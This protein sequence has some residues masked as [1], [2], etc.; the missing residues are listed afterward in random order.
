MRGSPANSVPVVSE[1]TGPDSVER[2]RRLRELF[3]AVLDLPPTDRSSFLARETAGDEVLRR[4]VDALVRSAELTQV[5]FELNSLGSATDGPSLVGQRLGAYDVVRLIGLGGM[6]A[7]YEAV[8]ADDQYRQR[9][10]I[11]LVQRGLDSD[12]TAQRFR[13]E[14]QILASLA[15]RNIA[16]LLDGGVSA[17]GRPYLVMEYVEGEPITRWCDMRKLPLPARLA[18]FRQVC[19]AVQ[20]AHQNLVVH[21]DLKPGNILVTA[22]GTVKLLDFGIAKLMVDEE[23]EDGMPLTRGGA[24]ILTPEYASPEQL[25]GMPLSTVSDV[26]SLGVL[27][28]ELVSG[29]RPHIA[30][31]RAML[32]LEQEILTTTAPRSSTLATNEAAVARGERSGDRLR[33]RLRGELDNIIAMALR[34]EPERRYA[35]VEALADDLRRHLDGLPVKAQRDWAGYRLRKFVQRN[36]GVV[37]ASALLLCS[38]V[39]GVL[40]STAQA[41][42]ARASQLQSERVNGFLTS[43]LSSVRPAT[44]G[45]DVS[46]GEVLDAVA[47]KLDVELAGEP[48]VRNDLETVVGQSYLSLGRFDDAER[49]FHAAEAAASRSSGPRSAAVIRAMVNLGSVEIQR[50]EFDRADSIFRQ[51]EALRVAGKVKDETL[52]ALI[53]D[54]FGS[55][56]HEVGRL[57]DA[58][59]YHR[60]AMDL[61]IA[62]LGPQNDD[63]AYSMGSV[64]VALGELGRWSEAEALN[65]RSL[66]ILLVNHP[67]PNP[68]VSDAYNALA[69]TL[70]FEGKTAAAESA[71]VETLNIRRVLYGEQHPTYAWTL[72]NYSMF[73]FDQKRFKEAAEY[74]RQILALR[75]T[76]LPESHPSIAAALQ[77]LGRCLDQLGEFAGGEAALK[78]SLAIRRKYNPATSWLI[79]SSKSVLGEHYT[80]SKDFPRAES[81]LLPSHAVFVKT[82]GPAHARTIVSA[83]RLVAL[84]DAWGRPIKAAPYRAVVDSAKGS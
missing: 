1:A 7:V 65:R 42:R 62:I 24:R 16:T 20:H 57:D 53:L 2:L 81:L 17:D 25:Q 75:G 29:R 55:V 18:L 80:L 39:A 61:R 23:T 36:R 69:G 32:E 10:A 67:E 6:G 77:T 56:A 58:E 48:A 13:R 68:L 41:R 59:K 21:R 8:R 64:A 43:I 73:I 52:R 15:H 54:E 66:A 82:F 49:H 83:K 33:H 79:A 70:D 3:D 28:F 51:A 63:V 37:T 4:E 19:S 71:Y 5:P 50:G 46:V 26:Y 12:V 9:V 30:D 45:K 38:L 47:R 35:S 74:S 60:Q 14:R 22:D 44:G 31:G 34:K 72:F 78:E 11:K 27:L 76:V 84:Y 40:V